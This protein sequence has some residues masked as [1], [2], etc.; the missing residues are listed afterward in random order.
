MEHMTVCILP[1]KVHPMRLCTFTPDR[2]NCGC[3]SRKDACS[4]FGMRKRGTGREV[5]VAR[6]RTRWEISEWSRL[7][8]HHIHPRDYSFCKSGKQAVPNFRANH[9]HKKEIPRIMMQQR[10]SGAPFTHSRSSDQFLTRSVSHFA[11]ELISS[12]GF[13]AQKIGQKFPLSR[14]NVALSRIVWMK[15]VCNSLE[16]AQ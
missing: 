3:K 2:T 16:S 9:R 13:K 14:G 15:V 5:C 6:T 4:K 10:E 12:P 11:V 1:R 8:Q 7:L